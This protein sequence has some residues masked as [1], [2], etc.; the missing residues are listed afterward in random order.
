MG[1]W[2]KAAVSAQHL[3]PG[4]QQKLQRWSRVSLQRSENA[5]CA[6]ASSANRVL[7]ALPLSRANPSA[8]P[9]P[10][11]AGLW[12]SNSFPAMSQFSSLSPVCTNIFVRLSQQALSP[13]QL[14]RKEQWRSVSANQL[15]AC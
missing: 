15:L 12:P 1:G 6:D 9:H 4:T 8:Y 2:L 3:Q 14:A 7:S 13:V 10:P 5:L 11:T